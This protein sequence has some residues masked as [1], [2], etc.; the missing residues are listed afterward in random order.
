MDAKQMHEASRRRL[1]FQTGVV[2]KEFDAVMGR[3]CWRSVCSVCLEKRG[4]R[5]SVGDAAL[6]FGLRRSVLLSTEISPAVLAAGG[7]TFA[8]FRVHCLLAPSGAV[9]HR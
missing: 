8:V 1:L 2:G 3:G 7:E 9:D 6:P 4:E 5:A